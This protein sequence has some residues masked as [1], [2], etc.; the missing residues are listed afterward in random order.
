LAVVVVAARL[1]LVQMPL[2]TMVVTAALELLRQ[3][4]VRL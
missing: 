3:S 4:L 1:Q 2:A